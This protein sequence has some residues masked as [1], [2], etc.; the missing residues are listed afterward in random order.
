MAV[1][2]TKCGVTGG[3]IRCEVTSHNDGQNNVLLSVPK[4]NGLV[5][6]AKVEVP[7]PGIKQAVRGSSINTASQGLS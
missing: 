5:N 7:W 2:W 1:V 3:N 6:L 4:V